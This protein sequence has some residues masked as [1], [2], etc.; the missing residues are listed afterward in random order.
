MDNIHKTTESRRKSI[1]KYQ[2]EKTDRIEVR[3]PKDMK[4]DIQQYAE[5]SRI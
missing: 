2:Q 1:K 3:V 4:F 5:Y